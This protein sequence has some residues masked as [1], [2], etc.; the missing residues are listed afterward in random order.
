MCVCVCVHLYSLEN[1][2]DHL[3]GNSFPCC[4]GLGR[5]RVRFPSQGR[6]NTPSLQFA[7]DRVSRRATTENALLLYLGANRTRE[8]EHSVEANE[9]IRDRQQPFCPARGSLVD[10]LVPYCVCKVHLQRLSP[11]YWQQGTCWERS[12]L[13]AE[14]EEEW[15]RYHWSGTLADFWTGKI[16]QEILA[17]EGGWGWGS[18]SL[19]SQSLDSCPWTDLHSPGSW[20]MGLQLLGS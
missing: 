10:F 17:A 13:G 1:R 5:A 16:S 15:G 3:S 9:L 7:G 2:Q 20:M 19:W 18:L 8:A 14:Q 4:L 6:T 11:N 12:L